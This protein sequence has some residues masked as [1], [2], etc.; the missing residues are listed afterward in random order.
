MSS[1]KTLSS[2]KS[3]MFLA[4]IS[5]AVHVLQEIL[6]ICFILQNVSLVI[7]ISVSC[8]LF[9]TSLLFWPHLIIWCTLC[10]IQK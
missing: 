6:F 7:F 2:K 10:N 5:S 4:M 8:V 9:L 1:E 3:F